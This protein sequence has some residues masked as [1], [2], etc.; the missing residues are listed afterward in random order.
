M[1]DETFEHAMVHLALGDEYCGRMALHAARQREG[2]LQ[3]Y[4][5]RHGESESNVLGLITNRAGA[6]HPLTEKGRGR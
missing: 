5:V 1:C 3:L 2:N 4:F 6:S